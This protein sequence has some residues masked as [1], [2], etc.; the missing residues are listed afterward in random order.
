LLPHGLACY[1]TGDI[2][3]RRERALNKAYLSAAAMALLASQAALAADK[4]PTDQPEP[5]RQLV[6]CREIADAAARL[7]CYDKQV[8][9]L[10]QATSRHEIVIADKKAV[11]TAKRGLFGFATPVAKLM[12][13]GGNEDAA[14]ELKAVS[15]TVAGVR[16]TGAGWLIDFEDG[17]T[18]EQNDTREFVLSP[19]IGNKAEIA[20][21]V[22]GTF[23]VSVN[24][25]RP[26]KMRRVK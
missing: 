3:Q 22:L 5:Y 25:Q 17:S 1:Q 24:G 23:T 18:W 7:A 16:R 8:A 14:E 12:G 21:G 13:F 4:N 20:R 6:A 26:I 10:D 2:R 9:A 15:T 19:K 11:E